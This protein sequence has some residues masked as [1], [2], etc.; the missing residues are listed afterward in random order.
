M[1]TYIFT[2]DWNLVLGVVVSLVYIIINYHTKDKHM[3]IFIS[4]GTLACGVFL[5]WASNF[6]PAL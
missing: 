3:R 1:S 2:I 5:Q 4:I 6:L